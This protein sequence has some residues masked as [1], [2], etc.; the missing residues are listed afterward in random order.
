VLVLVLVLALA[1]LAGGCIRSVAGDGNAAWGGIYGHATAKPRAGTE[2][3]LAPP[4]APAG[5]RSKDPYAPSAPAPAAAPASPKM[6][7]MEYGRLDD[8]VVWLELVPGAPRPT[9][10][11]TLDPGALLAAPEVATTA[12]ARLEDGPA[13]KGDRAIRAGGVF[14]LLNA[15]SVEVTF[16]SVSEGNAFESPPLRP[17]EWHEWRPAA[18]GIVDVLCDERPEWR[19]RIVVAPTLRYETVRSGARFEWNGLPPGTYRVRASHWRLP[20]A[21]TTVEV[22]PGAWAKAELTLSVDALGG[23]PPR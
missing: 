10:E 12:E 1:P 11:E 2:A 14:R 4:A 17:G 6:P 23:A 3:I 5:K 8:I 19:L 22:R 15:T 16:V 13:A 18:P 9:R 21:E 20:E 7:R